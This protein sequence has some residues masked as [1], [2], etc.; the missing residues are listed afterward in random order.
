MKNNAFLLALLSACIWGM[1]PIFEKV[2]LNGRIDPYLGVVI[3]TIPIALIGLTGLILMGRIDS[4]FQI[5]IKSAAFVVIGGLIAG[6]AGQIVFYAALKSGE[7]SVVVPV[8]AT[9]PLVALIISVLF[10]G[11]AVTWQK[12]AGIGMVVGGVM[13]LK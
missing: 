2:G 10:L 11:E 6:F 9:Y 7:A 4:L 13:L 1:A 3:R 12:I 5:D 8:A